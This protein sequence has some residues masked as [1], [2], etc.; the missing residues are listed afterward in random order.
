MTNEI[1]EIETNSET[2][3]TNIPAKNLDT[4]VRQ[5]PRKVRGGIE[6]TEWGWQLHKESSSI[7]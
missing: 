5:P 2:E 6:G 3:D 7:Y 1:Q 4:G